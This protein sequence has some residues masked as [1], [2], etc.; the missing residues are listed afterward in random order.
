VAESEAPGPQIDRDASWI[1]QNRGPSTLPLKSG[2]TTRTE[3]GPL[4]DT[5]DPK[6][7]PVAPDR[8]SDELEIV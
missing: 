1:G 2:Q 7:S 6:L 8:H 4:A 5:G 3:E